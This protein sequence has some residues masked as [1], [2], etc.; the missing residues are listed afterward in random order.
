MEPCIP[1][2]LANFIIPQ[3]HGPFENFTQMLANL[4]TRLPVILLNF[5]MSRF[6][7]S[8]LILDASAL[9]AVQCNNLRIMLVLIKK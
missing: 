6:L 4:L 9:T 7:F 3:C 8:G 2:N 5:V 1:C